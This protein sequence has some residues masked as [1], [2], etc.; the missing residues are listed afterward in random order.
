MQVHIKNVSCRIL[1]DNTLTKGPRSII[2]ASQREKESWIEA[3]REAKD[4]YL[5]AKR[6]LKIGTYST[7]LLFQ[8]DHMN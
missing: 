4:E 1:Q 3:I 7:H 8:V 5:S 6:T 2:T